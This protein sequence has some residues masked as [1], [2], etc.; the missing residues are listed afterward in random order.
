MFTIAGDSFFSLFVTLVDAQLNLLL[1]NGCFF[2]SI[3]R[4]KKKTLFL[5]QR[6]KYSVK[7]PNLQQNDLLDGYVVRRGCL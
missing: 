5:S 6:H 1:S 7:G 4:Y 2:F 3:K